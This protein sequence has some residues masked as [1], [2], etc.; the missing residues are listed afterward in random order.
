MSVKRALYIIY[1]GRVEG[2]GEGDA[3]LLRILLGEEEDV[4]RLEVEVL[5]P[6]LVDVSEPAGHLQREPPFL[7]PG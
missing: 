4:A 6:L 1:Y 5:L 2:V 7:A 3:V